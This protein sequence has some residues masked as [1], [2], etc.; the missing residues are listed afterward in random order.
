M[1]IGYFARL[2]DW[3]LRITLLSIV[4]LLTQRLCHTERKQLQD[5]KKLHESQL[6]PPWQFFCQWQSILRYSRRNENNAV[7]L[8]VLLMKMQHR[9]LTGK[10]QTACYNIPG[11]M[12]I[13]EGTCDP[14]SY[15]AARKAGYQMVWID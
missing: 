14:V 4:R 1:F 13:K 15:D 8:V 12:L 10:R 2:L 6:L 3:S 9:R 5:R 11:P 7:P